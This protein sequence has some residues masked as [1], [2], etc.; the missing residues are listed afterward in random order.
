MCQLVMHIVF[1]AVAAR[2]PAGAYYHVFKDCHPLDS[3][4]TRVPPFQ[5]NR[6]TVHMHRG[7]THISSQTSRSGSFVTD[8]PDYVLHLELASDST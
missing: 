2:T 5:V 8:P 6:I 7:P 1:Q 4:Y 3:I